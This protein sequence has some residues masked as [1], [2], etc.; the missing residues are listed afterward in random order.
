MTLTLTPKTEAML[1]A[2]AEDEGQDINTLA[3]TLL[4]D[5]LAHDEAK[6]IEEPAAAMDAGPMSGDIQA[7][8]KVLAD[9]A[10]E[11]D[12]E[13]LKVLLFLAA[14]EVRLLY[15]DA[16]ARPTL[17][18]E[19]IAPFY[20]GPDRRNGIHHPFAVALIRPEEEGRLRLPDGWGTWEDAVVI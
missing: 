6:V 20:F 5:M 13:T 14:D 3:D 17:D 4:A 11:A 7:T 15:V 2:R 18:D 1:L 16:T 10:R 8:A 19:T 9:A 12:S